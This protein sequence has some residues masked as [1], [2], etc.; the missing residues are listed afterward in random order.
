MDKVLTDL[1]RF[2]GH[3]P[4]HRLLYKARQECPAFF[5]T[6]IYVRYLKFRVSQATIPGQTDH[7]DSKFDVYLQYV[8][9]ENVNVSKWGAIQF[10]KLKIKLDVL[11]LF[12]RH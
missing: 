9:G 11:K 7:Q 12:G 1:S 8:A 2:D 5:G 4:Y 10:D 6:S 3:Q